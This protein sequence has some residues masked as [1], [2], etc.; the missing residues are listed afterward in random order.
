MKLELQNIG[1]FTGVHK[2]ELKKG[3]NRITAP[4]AKGKSSLLRGIECLA[5]D[6]A[7]IF[8]DSLNAGSD[9][10]YV[11]LDDKY[12]RQLMRVGDTVQAD[13]SR[14]HTFFDEESTWRTAKEIVFFTPKSRVVQEIG[15]N[16]FDVLGFVKRVS[17]ADEIE[18][19]IHRTEK[20]LDTK[21]QELAEYIENLKTAQK[22]EAE[23][24]TLHGEVEKLQ[25][26]VKKL[27]DAVEAETGKKDLTKVRDDIAKKKQEI[28][29]FEERLRSRE[30]EV[31]R[32]REQY[33]DAKALHERL[34]EEIDDFEQRYEKKS[35]DEFNKDIGVYELRKKYLNTGKDLLDG[36]HVLVDKAYKAYGESERAI[37]ETVKDD[38]HL[39]RA[40]SLLGD[41][42]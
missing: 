27:E 26:E 7:N 8:G 17:G 15:Q 31:R 24:G 28:H 33:E 4:N 19:N 16:D 36:L 42:G 40:Y 21:K 14:D 38:P 13:T 37:P 29:N 22:F 9:S 3:I 25:G 11:K 35:L 1:G 32:Y 30:G 39:N 41:P 18:D 34:E 10:G 2:F 20:R 23:I 6:D 5:R 12:V